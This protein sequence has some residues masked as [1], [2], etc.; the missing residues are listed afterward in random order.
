MAARDDI[1]GPIHAGPG[2][3]GADVARHTVNVSDASDGVLA[4]TASGDVSS[5]ILGGDFVRHGPD[6]VITESG[7]SL[8]IVN[9]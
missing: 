1:D 4:V 6:L 2:Q 8:L 5:L 7:R 3:S 9:Y